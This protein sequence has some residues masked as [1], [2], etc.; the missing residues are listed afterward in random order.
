MGKLRIIFVVAIVSII[1]I[2]LKFCSSQGEFCLFGTSENSFP[3][4]RREYWQSVNNEYYIASKKD[5]EKCNQETE[6]ARI[7]LI[8]IFSQLCSDEH[9]SPEYLPDAISFRHNYLENRYF[10]KN[11]KILT[12]TTEQILIKFLAGNDN[13]KFPSVDRLNKA[14]ALYIPKDGILYDYGIG[15]SIGLYT[16]YYFEQCMFKNN[17]KR[18]VPKTTNRSC[19]GIGW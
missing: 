3:D 6:N 11:T 13:N 15:P 1:T 2:N 8:N 19:R 5:I 18:I 17:F 14:C 9:I 12:G 16:N 10:G 4:Q 7:V